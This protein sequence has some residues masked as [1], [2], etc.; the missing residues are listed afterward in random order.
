M[1][2]TNATSPQDRLPKQQNSLATACGRSACGMGGGS[3]ESP[4][5]FHTFHLNFGRIMTEQPGREQRP[6]NRPGRP[7]PTPREVQERVQTARPSR[8]EAERRFSSGRLPGGNLGE[9]EVRFEGEIVLWECRWCF[10]LVRPERREQHGEVHENNRRAL[11]AK[12]DKPETPE[13]P[14][15]P[16]GPRG[17]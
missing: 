16:A 13:T 12:A 2:E 8:E 1:A 15:P 4:R 7:A 10:A 14:L 9:G 5:P 17:V 3:A 6:I 11:N